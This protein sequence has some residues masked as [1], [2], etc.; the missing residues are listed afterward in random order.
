MLERDLALPFRIDL[1]RT[2]HAVRRGQH[3]PCCRFD[4]EI[5]WRAT[6]TPA[7]PATLRLEPLGGDRVVATAWGDGAEAALDGAAALIGC[8]D[9]ATSFAPEH[10]LVRRLWRDHADVRIPRSGAVAETLVN[11]VLEQRVTTYEARRAQVQL[12][13]RWGEPAPGPG[14]LR[15]PPDPEILAGVAYY[16]LHVLGVERKRADTVRRVAASARQLDALATVPIAAAHDRLLRVPGVGPWSAAEVA[17]VALGDA[18][19]VPVGDVH[20]P[21]IVTFALTGTAIDDDDA[22]LEVLEPFAGHRGRV[23]RLL[24]ITGVHAPRHGPRYAPRDVRDQ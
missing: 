15:L 23:I 17:L 19:A 7:G 2:L 12:V 22:M 20:L 13:E 4:G 18:D 5:V 14:D 16:D 8:H 11:V 6:R 9:D 24:Q 10:P 1:R 3:D 21:S